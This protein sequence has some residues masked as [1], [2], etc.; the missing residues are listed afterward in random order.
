[1]RRPHRLVPLFLG[2]AATAAWAAPADRLP[3]P[4]PEPCI[5][6][7]VDPEEGAVVAPAGLSYPEVKLALS[8]VIQTA[9]YCGRPAGMS[10]VHLTYD[11]TVGCDGVVSKIETVDDGGAP[12]DYVKCVSDVVAKADFPAHDMED[13]MLVTYPV[14]VSW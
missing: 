6:F 10:E 11:L 7:D 8:A 12:A 2:I 3:D 5:P 4:R 9:L 14:D 13:G 1:M